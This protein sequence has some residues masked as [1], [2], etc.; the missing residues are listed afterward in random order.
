MLVKLIFGAFLAV[1]GASA[2]VIHYK[3]L[4]EHIK[5][6]APPVESKHCKGC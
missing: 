6:Y 5:K 1:A 2:L 3:M 4:D